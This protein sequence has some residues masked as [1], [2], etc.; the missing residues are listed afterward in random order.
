MH[1]RPLSYFIPS[2]FFDRLSNG[3]SERYLADCP[4]G[5]RMRRVDRF[6]TQ[7]TRIITHCVSVQHCDISSHTVAGYAKLP[8]LRAAGDIM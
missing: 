2:Q 8:I 3:Y 6:A 1:I 4:Q 5:V 7:R